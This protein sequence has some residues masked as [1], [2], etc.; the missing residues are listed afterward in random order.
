MSIDIR[1]AKATPA[2]SLKAYILQHELRPGDLLPTEPEL[3]AELGVSRTSVR[4]AVRTLASLD[5]IEV[6]HGRGTFVG[7]LSLAPLVNGLVFR[8]VLNTDATFRE[9]REVVELRIALDLSVADELVGLYQGTDN[10]ALHDLVAAMRDR[11]HAG[12]SFM[13]E[14]RAFHAQLLA[15]VQNTLL[16][17]LAEAF[18]QVHTDVVPRLG[19]SG[20]DD[21]ADTV[22]AHGDMLAALEDGDTEAYRT[23]V[24]AHFAPLQRAID[25]GAQP[26]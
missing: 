17:Q 11:M 21:I 1:P 23:A 10:D 4:E 8:S 5:I 22:E 24:I 3:C 13:D 2:E 14:D 18:W 7:G 12:Q 26:L 6:R 16:R 20:S 15:P 25:R 19:I 9:L